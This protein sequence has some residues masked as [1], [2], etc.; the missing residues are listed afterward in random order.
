V[1]DIVLPRM[2][3]MEALGR[4]REIDRRVGIIML[5]AVEDESVA[6]EAMQ[7]EAYD[8]ITKPLD[9]GYLELAI[10]TKLAQAAG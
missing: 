9:V 6:R 7:R 10:L 8:Y 1:T 2:S 4:I 3:G 5:T